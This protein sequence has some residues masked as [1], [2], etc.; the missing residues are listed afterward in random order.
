MK[1]YI[2]TYNECREIVKKYPPKTFFENKKLYDKYKFSFFNYRLAEHKH[3]LESNAFEMKGITFFHHE[4]ISKHYLMFNKFWELNQYPE[5]V[6]DNFKDK[7]IKKVMMKEDG[8]L[9][10]FIDLPDGRIISRVKQ[11]FLSNFNIAA[12]NFIKQNDTYYNF[13]KYC[14]KND[15]IPLFEL[16]GEHRLVL[17][18]PKNDLILLNLRNNLTGEYLDNIDYDMSGINVVKKVNYNL[19]EL[20]E[21][22]KKE[23][24]IEGWVVQFEDDTLLKIKTEWF[25]N[26]NNYILNK[27]GMKRHK[28]INS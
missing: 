1:Y 19:E 24:Y 6:Y 10:S 13:I 3:F 16:V 14:L 27:L 7:K 2:P 8:N 12:N 18:Y 23:K 15:I 9:I 11:G 20:I 17:K 5:F 4:G 28:T 21:L 22:S 26:M 25:Y